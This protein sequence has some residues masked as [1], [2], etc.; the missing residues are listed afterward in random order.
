MTHPEVL[1]LAVVRLTKGSL[2]LGKLI[3]PAWERCPK[4]LRSNLTSEKNAF[5][6]LGLLKEANNI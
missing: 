6:V 3:G 4:T 2:K 5:T 1:V